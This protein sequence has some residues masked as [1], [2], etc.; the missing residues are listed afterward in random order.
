VTLLGHLPMGVVIGRVV[1]APHERQILD[2]IVLSVP[3]LVVDDEAVARDVVRKYLMADGHEVVTAANAREGLEDFQASSFDLVVTDH[4]MPGM[5]GTQLAGSIKAARPGQPI[6][7]LTGFS[8]PSR[9][10][11]QR[12]AG[13]DLMLTKPIPQKDLREALAQLCPS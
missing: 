7:M 6:L 12:P 13:V 8:D 5:N 11:Q 9:N 4:A 1:G 10:T 3:V 2:A